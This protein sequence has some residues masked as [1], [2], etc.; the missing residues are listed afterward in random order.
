MRIGSVDLMG[1]GI[2]A[3]NVVRK[4]DVIESEFVD[5]LRKVTQGNSVLNFFG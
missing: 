2:P 3:D 5:R 4:H 1:C